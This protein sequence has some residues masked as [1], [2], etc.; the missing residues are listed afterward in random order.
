VRGGLRSFR[1]VKTPRESELLGRT[2]GDSRARGSQTGEKGL[3]LGIDGAV[4]EEEIREE[5]LSP[6]KGEDCLGG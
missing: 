2:T 1:K 3:C 6:G 5:S 4:C